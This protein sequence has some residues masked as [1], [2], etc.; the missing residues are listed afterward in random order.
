MFEFIKTYAGLWMAN[1]ELSDKVRGLEILV[2]QYKEA[3]EAARKQIE[4]L[5]RHN[6]FR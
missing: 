6:L 3:L 4:T 1:R 2:V 5:T